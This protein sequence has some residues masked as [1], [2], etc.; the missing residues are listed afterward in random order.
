MLIESHLCHLQSLQELWSSHGLVLVRYK[1]LPKGFGLLF[2]QDETLL[3]SYSSFL[4]LTESIKGLIS[5]LVLPP[6]FLVCY[7]S[8]WGF[9]S[10]PPFAYMVMSAN[11]FK[12]GLN[13]K[14]PPTHPTALCDLTFLLTY[15]STKLKLWDSLY[16]S[17]SFV[18]DISFIKNKR[19]I[20]IA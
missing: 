7:P 18:P 5:I 9:S 10:R 16:Y 20:A 3:A 8:F 17:F 11:P 2:Y 4:K 15:C 12:Y 19:V 13:Q 14:A 6:F 1:K